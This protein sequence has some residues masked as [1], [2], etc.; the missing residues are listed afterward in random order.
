V[1]SNLGAYALRATTFVRKILMINHKRPRELMITDIINREYMIFEHD[2]F[3][4]NNMRCVVQVL[5]YV[6]ALELTKGRLSCKLS[7]ST[8]LDTLSTIDRKRPFRRKRGK[9]RT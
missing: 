3:P 4:N 2:G 8:S 1:Y 9:S 5:T 7:L 6:V